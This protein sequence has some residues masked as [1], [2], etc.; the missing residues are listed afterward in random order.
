MNK[1][2][3]SKVIDLILH[4]RKSKD[5][6]FLSSVSKSVGI[7]WSHTVRLV[8]LME[9]ANWVKTEK[10]GRTRYIS[11]TDEGKEIANELRKIT[12]ISEAISS[13]HASKK[14]VEK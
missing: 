7:C 5:K 11:L 9:N 2:I 14:V 3:S 12:Y 1:L 10:V 13:S 8:R 6:E 4:L